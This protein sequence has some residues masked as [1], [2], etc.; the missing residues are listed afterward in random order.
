MNAVKAHVKRWVF[1]DESRAR[2]I[3]VG[4][5]RG[6]QFVVDPRE[7][8]QRLLGLDEREI[9]EHV[10][11]GADRARTA[12]DV[13]CHDG[14]YTTFF[15][16]RPNIAKALACD[17]D[18]VVLDLL[19][20]NVNLNHLASRVAVH[21]LSVGAS[22]DGGFRSL[23]DLLRHETPPFVIKV[24]VDGGELDVLTS[25]RTVLVE[26][27]C[28]VIVETHS[29]ELERDCMRYLQQLGYHTRVIPN[30]WYRMFVP[31]F[32]PTA[33]NRWFVATRDGL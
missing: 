17:R 2:H 25:G 4:L 32:R 31:E 16:S 15:A 1:G 21:R 28:A 22:T 3:H 24:D 9:A 19:M 6:L 7:K 29:L 14:W 8:S 30:G 12:I 18:Q 33:H 13:G 5:L 26:Q 11:H 23:D 10:R 20:R 27:D